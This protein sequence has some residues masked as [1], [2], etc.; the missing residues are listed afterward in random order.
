[1]PSTQNKQMARRSTK[2]STVLVV[3]ATGVLG[4]EV[5][6]Q[7]AA[8]GKRVKG[9]VRT[10]SQ[11]EKIGGLHELG[12]EAVTGDMKDPQS[13]YRAFQ[14][15]DAIISTA[16]STISHQEGD[17]I[18]TV[19]VAGQLNVAEAA[20]AVGAQHAVFISFPPYPPMT[21]GFPL[22]SAKRAVE[23]R[24][25]SK[26]FTYT[27]L[28]PTYFMELWLGPALGFDYARAK[29]VIYGEG[30]NKISWIAIKDVASFAV[31]SIDNPAAQ[32]TV[33]QL[34]GPD[35]LSVLDAVGIF[36]QESGQTFE[37]QNVPDEALRA[38]I[39]AAPDSRGKT[40][41]GLMIGLN[42]VGTIDM[43]ETLRNFPIQLTSVRD[44]ARQ[45]IVHSVSERQHNFIL[46][47]GRVP[48]V[49]EAIE[50]MGQWLR[51]KLLS[52]KGRVA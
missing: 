42:T 11:E 14:N 17:S 34:G 51:S 19:D 23:S 37:L 27:I 18:E 2:N 31:A 1:M 22:R 35:D 15:V 8:A 32:N 44:Y 7:L 45:M 21:P 33:I 5:C 4:M 26:N 36:E 47:A 16:T 38:Q 29:A 28:Q 20:S 41:R 52:V 12:V 24:L 13:L 3:G 48:E 30:K 10:S 50:Q 40:F 49:D 39:A 9:L 43:K 6:R 46:G 25:R